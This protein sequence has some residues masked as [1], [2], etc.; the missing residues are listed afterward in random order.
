MFASSTRYFTKQSLGAPENR[1]ASML[2]YQNLNAAETGGE[3]YP[4]LLILLN[5][6]YLWRDYRVAQNYCGL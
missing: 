1:D 2:F 6:S 5:L 3:G 4:C